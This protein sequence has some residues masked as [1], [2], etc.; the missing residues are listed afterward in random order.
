MSEKKILVFVEDEESIL[1]DL[2]ILFKRVG[3]KVRAFSEAHKA[4]AFLAKNHYDLVCTDI[5]MPVPED[6]DEEACEF[7]KKTGILLAQT[8]KKLKP[9]FP[10]MA[11]TVAGDD[12]EMVRAMRKAGISRI[13]SKPTTAE[14]LI[15]VV[16]E[17]L[18]D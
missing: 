11:L 8:I 3:Y 2:V 13:L 9:N 12:P 15:A 18:G 5:V 4:V 16:K 14:K 6:W 10:I 1:N 17:M 7:G